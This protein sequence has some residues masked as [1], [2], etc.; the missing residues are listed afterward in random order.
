M[1]GLGLRSGSGGKRGGG[2]TRGL[3]TGFGEDERI[4]KRYGFKG[5]QSI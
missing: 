4:E 3:E 5:R 2:G 1:D